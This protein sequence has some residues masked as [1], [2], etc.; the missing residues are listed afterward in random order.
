MGL[1]ACLPGGVEDG[2]RRTHHHD[3]TCESGQR[4]EHKA[5]AQESDAEEGV[6][7]RTH[8]SEKLIPSDSFAPTT[9]NSSAPPFLGPTETAPGVV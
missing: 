8:L 9:A 4:S 5:S 1:P 3:S 2:E 7:E 6:C